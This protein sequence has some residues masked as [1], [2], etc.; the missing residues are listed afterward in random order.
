MCSRV[1]DFIY[2]RSLF[3]E[4][5]FVYFTLH[6]QSPFISMLLLIIILLLITFLITI[7]SF[8]RWSVNWRSINTGYETSCD[9]A[10]KDH[11]RAAVSTPNVTTRLSCTLILPG[12]LAAYCLQLLKITD[13]YF[14]TVSFKWC[15]INAADRFTVMIVH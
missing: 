15:R 6:W 14:I 11:L 10:S 2:Q 9:R 7:V 8:S 1:I 13:N 5:R 12:L 4:H 3:I